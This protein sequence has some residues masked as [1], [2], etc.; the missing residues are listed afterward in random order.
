MNFEPMP[1]LPDGLTAAPPPEKWDQWV[2]D[3]AR[4]WPREG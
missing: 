3:D 2:E 1:F 4:A